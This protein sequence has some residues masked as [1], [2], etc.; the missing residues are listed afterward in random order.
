MSLGEIGERNLIRRLREL[1]GEP[2]ARTLVGIGDDAAVIDAA[3]RLLVMTTDAY[4][5][6]IHFR[7]DYISPDQVGE[8]ILA[9]TVSDCAAMGCAPR[10]V[11]I[12]LA[13]PAETPF[14]QIEALYHGLKRGAAKYGCDIVGGDTV[15]TLSDLTI[16]LTAV[17]EPLGA[18][19]LTRQG[20][21][22]GDDV[23]VT[24]RLGGAMAGLLLFENDP[25]STLRPEL[26]P[27]VLRYLAPE[28]RLDAAR[29][30]AA[31][32]P[33]TSLIDLSDGLSVDLY[34]L[35]RESKVGFQLE[36]DRIPAEPSALRIAEELNV[37]NDLIVLHGGEEFELLFT[38]PPGEEEAL[39][40]AL[41]TEVDLEVT[42]IG[43]VVEEEEGVQLVDERGEGEPLPEEGY[44]HFRALYPE[45]GGEE[46]GVE[47]ADG[48]E[49]EEGGTI[50]H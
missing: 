14:E 8:K 44:E 25:K 30:L 32:F 26:R 15:S 24:G 2:S 10:W 21:E 40:E 17:G 34:H 37:S 38:A 50:T 6:W 45:P 39:I 23:Y 4:T 33:I 12:A 5:E 41:R 1:L 7:F 43:M 42:R 27:S 47:G 29:V 22:V 48:P 13:A 18:R 19:V 36:R 28:A 46:E 49:D 9:A 35:A 16:S 31:R 20:A 3:G 11:T